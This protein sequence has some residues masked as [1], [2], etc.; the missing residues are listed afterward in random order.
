MSVIE[1]AIK[2]LQASR[3]GTAATTRGKEYGAAATSGG[4]AMAAA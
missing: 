3:A 2:R 1:N 4:V